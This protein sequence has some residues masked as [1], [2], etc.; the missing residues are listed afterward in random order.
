MRNLK[1]ALLGLGSVVAL[2]GQAPALAAQEPYEP[3]SHLCGGIGVDGRQ[4]M[5]AEGKEY[6]VHLKFANARTGEFLAGL[7]VHIE[8]LGDKRE[9]GPFEDCGP[10]LYVRLAPGNYRVSAEYEGK[11]V[12]Q[13]IKVGKKPTDHVLYWR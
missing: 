8:H 2:L 7:K 1:Q 6:N 9:M 5:Q 10:L 13:N 11:V 4:A 12:A 3:G